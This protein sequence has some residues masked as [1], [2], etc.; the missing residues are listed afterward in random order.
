MYQEL[1]AFI[2][3]SRVNWESNCYIWVGSCKKIGGFGG[4]GGGWVRGKLRSL[5]NKTIKLYLS[6]KDDVFCQ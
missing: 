2:S 1:L 3:I 6:L 5:H 4:G